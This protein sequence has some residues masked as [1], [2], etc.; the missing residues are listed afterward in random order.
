MKKLI[1]FLG[2]LGVSL[3]A[4]FIRCSTA[5]SVV[6]VIYRVGIAT[7]LLTPYVFLYHRPELRL[8]KWKEL[9][10]CLLSGAFLGLHFIAYFESLRY[11]TIAAAVVLVN[12]EALFVALGAVLFMKNRLS[13]R[14]W[15]A[16]L[17]TFAGSVI[18]AMADATGGTGGTMRGNLLA[19]V[20]AVFAAVYTLLGAVCRRG[21]STTIYTYFVYMSAGLTVLLITVLSGVPL[22]GYGSVN[23]LT[24]LGM[25]V[26]CTLMGHSVYSWSLKYLPASFVATVKLTEP[27]FAAAWGLIF[28]RE[29]PH[30]LVIAGGAVVLL[31][32]ALYSRTTAKDL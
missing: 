24:A 2:T 28:F 19:L 20:G 16:V 15:L 30:F 8:L 27:V 10:M 6:L 5:P 3:S 4:V 22:T 31:G 12:T 11:T 32:I 25:A 7:L 9:R 21:I 13:G 18:V 29:Q 1:V 14:A 17:M 23:Y 26:F